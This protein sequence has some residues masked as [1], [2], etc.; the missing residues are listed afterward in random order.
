MINKLGCGYKN[1]TSSINS[2]LDTT[3]YNTFVF[4]SSQFFS[5]G[6]SFHFI[7]F[8]IY[9]LHFLSSF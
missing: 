2:N 3:I 7:A 6:Q 8:A 5:H 4:S 1:M 9:N